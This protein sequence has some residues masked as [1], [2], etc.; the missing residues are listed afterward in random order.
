MSLHKHSFHTEAA[1]R[2]LCTVYVAKRKLLG[3]CAAG[4]L[5]RT[6]DDEIA[7]EIAKCSA[8]ENVKTLVDDWMDYYNKDRYQWDLLKLSPK[9]YY[10]YIQTGRYPLTE[11]ER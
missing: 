9:E 5:L 10:E 1:R 3:Q 2:K 6:Y 11:Y 8:Y 7:Y 4:E